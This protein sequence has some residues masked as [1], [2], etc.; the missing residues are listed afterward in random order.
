MNRYHA[1]IMLSGRNDQ[2]RGI[3][4]LSADPKAKTDN[5]SLQRL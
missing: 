3:E 4:E 2:S 5:T 1:V